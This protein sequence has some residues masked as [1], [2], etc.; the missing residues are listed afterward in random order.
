MMV[1][2]KRAYEILL[3]GTTLIRINT[4]HFQE[5]SN[6]VSI[7]R[8]SQII[9]FFFKYTFIFALYV[10]LIGKFG[11]RKIIERTVSHNLLC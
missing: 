2:Q 11:P 9:F 6:F 5:L 7:N 1:G 3:T 8:L 10:L 4:L